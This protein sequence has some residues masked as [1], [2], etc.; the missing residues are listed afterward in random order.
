MTGAT[1]TIAGKG[2]LVITPP[3]AANTK[4]L[5][6]DATWANTPRLTDANAQSRT[7][8]V[9]GEVTGKMLFD[10]DQAIGG[11]VADLDPN[12]LDFLINKP[13]SGFDL[14]RN[15]L[16]RIYNTVAALKAFDTT[17]WALSQMAYILETKE[18]V[19]F[20]RNDPTGNYKPTTGPGSWLK[21]SDILQGTL[22]DSGTT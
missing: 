21:N 15:M 8:T 2:G 18:F 16:P 12:G 6:G 4:F 22:H 20:N 11:V 5:R 10:R 17:T 9:F 7:S 14:T 1:A 13:W 19:I 3:I